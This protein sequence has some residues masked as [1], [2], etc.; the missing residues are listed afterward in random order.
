MSKLSKS[1]MNYHAMLEREQKKE[2]ER[3]EKERLRRLMVSIPS[4]PV[5]MYIQGD[6]HIEVA[7]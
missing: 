2:Q 1:V 4:L 3:I 6:F 5:D 7:L